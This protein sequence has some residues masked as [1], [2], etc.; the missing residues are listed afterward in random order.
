[1]N[2]AEKKRTEE[3]A[4]RRAIRCAAWVRALDRLALAADPRNEAFEEYALRWVTEYLTAA[5]LGRALPAP[6]G[7]LSA[8][9]REGL[10]REAESAYTGLQEYEHALARAGPDGAVAYSFESVA[11]PAAPSPVVVPISVARRRRDA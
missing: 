3:R 10:V 8:A 1:M 6:P 11:A 4:R 7:H 2:R 5:I 9:W